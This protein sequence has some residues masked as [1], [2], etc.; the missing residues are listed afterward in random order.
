MDDSLKKI[1]EIIIGILI[2]I[3]VFFNVWHFFWKILAYLSSF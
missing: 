3:V 1:I 2:L